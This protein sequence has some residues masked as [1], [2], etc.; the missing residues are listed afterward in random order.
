MKSLLASRTF[1]LA[2]VQGIG[3]IAIVGLT[4]L[5]LVGYAALVKSFV[6]IVLRL[7]TTEPVT[8]K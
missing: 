1:W 7:D 4:E 2:V 8:L 6:D 3:G 5:D